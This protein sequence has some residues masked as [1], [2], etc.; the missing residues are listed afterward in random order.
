MG[1]FISHIWQDFRSLS[2]TFPYFLSSIIG[3]YIECEKC[4]KDALLIV[5]IAI[6]N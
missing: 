4:H 2:L 5:I 1:I 3:R 6:D